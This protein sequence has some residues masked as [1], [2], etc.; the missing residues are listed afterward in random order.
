M[1]EAMGLK[2]GIDLP[3]LLGVRKILR[4]A[5][6]AEALYGFTPEAGLPLGFQPATLEGARTA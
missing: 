2:T 5:L 3:K 4:D 6:P 1:L